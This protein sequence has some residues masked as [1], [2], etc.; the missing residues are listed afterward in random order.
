MHCQDGDIRLVN[1][2]SVLNTIEG[3]VEICYASMWRGVY[4]SY[5]KIP[6]TVREAS[7]VCRQ[8]HYAPVAVKA[9]TTSENKRGSGNMAFSVLYCIGY[10]KKLTDCY[11]SPQG[12]LDLYYD[13]YVV[14]VGC[15]GEVKQLDNMS[16]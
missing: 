9:Y 14:S 16:Y 11:H 5:S 6:W 3:S 12:Y 13:L 10:E 1:V 15:Q 4:A 7:V 2:T 8:L